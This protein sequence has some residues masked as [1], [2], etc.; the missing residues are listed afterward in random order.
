MHSLIAIST[1]ACTAFF[2]STADSW[3]AHLLASNASSASS[4]SP[5]NARMVYA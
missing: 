3:A 4:V 2:A 1:D 5:L